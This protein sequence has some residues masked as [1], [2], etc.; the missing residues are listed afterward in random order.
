[1][2]LLEIQLKVDTLIETSLQSEAQLKFQLHE[3][4]Q[5]HPSVFN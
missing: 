4:L 5:H 3:Y 1:M 2:S